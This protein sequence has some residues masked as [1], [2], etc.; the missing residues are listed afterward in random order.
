MIRT[1]GE[2]FSGFYQRM[3]FLWNL[4]CGF[5]IEALIFWIGFFA[6]IGRRIT[7]KLISTK[8]LF[9]WKAH[10]LLSSQKIMLCMIC[11]IDILNKDLHMFLYKKQKRFLSTRIRSSQ[12]QHISHDFWK[13]STEICFEFVEVIFTWEVFLDFLNF[14]HALKVTISGI[15]RFI[16]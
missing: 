15:M 9:Y 8:Y 1:R 16:L 4:C 13:N 6:Y 12:L 3:Y 2:H 11:N 7:H 10:I 5:D 14:L